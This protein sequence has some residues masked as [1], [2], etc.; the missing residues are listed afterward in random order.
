M[1]N[2]FS[3]VLFFALAS[4]LFFLPS[5]A[6]VKVSDLVFDGMSVDPDELEN[7]LETIEI[8]KKK[9]KKKEALGSKK[10]LP[11]KL[12]VVEA[13]LSK[14]KEIQLEIDTSEVVVKT[15]K[16]IQAPI[17]NTSF[18]M[19]L[20][21]AITLWDSVDIADVEFLPVKFGSGQPDAEDGKFVVT[22]RA[23]GEKALEDIPEGTP[24]FT[25]L[26]Y[27]RTKN[28]V[29]MGKPIM[30]KAG[31]I[32]DA[33]IIFDPSNDP[34]LALHTTEGDF[35]I[36]GDD[37]PTS[38]GGIDPDADLSNCE[39]VRAGDITDLAVRSIAHLL[40]LENSPIA[41]AATAPVA[42]I[43]TRY[44]LTND[45]RIGL[46]NI[47]P[48]KT[49]LTNFGGI[50]GKV[51]LNK[52]P[53]VGAHIVLEDSI[54]G[55]PVTST[56]S[57]LKGKFKIDFVPAGTYNVYIEPLDGPGRKAA[58]PLNFFAFNSKTN[59]ITKVLDEPVTITAGKKTNLKNIEVEEISAS[60]FNINY[61]T[62]VLTEEDVN[63]TGGSFILPIRIMP[64]ETLTDIPLWGSNINPAFGTLSISGTGLTISNVKEN[65][66]I[67][68]SP[69]FT[70][71]DCTDTPETMCNRDPRC[72]PNTQEIDK[73]PDE[74]PGIVADI[75]CD[76]NTPPGPRNIIFTGDILE[77][78]NPSF[79]LRD[80]ITGG[81]I[82]TEE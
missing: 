12:E 55:E 22:F 65:K 76:P 13:K 36:G 39:F 56:I 33:D 31:T 15:G 25:V 58:F 44:A 21:E 27:A 34:C 51:T 45:D 57:D 74:I 17:S 80:Q 4:F 61:L 81:I 46:A 20:Q 60:S 47:Y 49:A 70:C 11:A 82:V 73:E 23:T 53:V 67:P 59:F 41:S 30:A 7:T 9:N 72:D 50:F 69:F 29:F 43:M 28:P 32:L 48:L 18:L 62:T 2:F 3:K 14:P 68:I 35:M 54:S 10:R 26:T 71:A 6:F 75:T 42:Q 38:D 77:P 1:K 63:G 8:N 52:K 79:G 19:A 16:D 5:N 40:G 66:S 37:V 64:G 78:T 24:V